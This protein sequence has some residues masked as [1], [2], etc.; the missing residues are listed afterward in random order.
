MRDLWNILS[1]TW[2][3]GFPHKI[4]ASDK[5]WCYQF[6]PSGKPESLQWKYPSLLKHKKCKMQTSSGKV[7][8]T[9]F[10]DVTCSLQLIFNRH[11]HTID[12]LHRQV[13]FARSGKFNNRVIL[14]HDNASPHV[15]KVVQDELKNMMR[16]VL[17]YPPYS[18]NL[19]PCPLHVYGPLKNV[20]TKWQV[21]LGSASE[22]RCHW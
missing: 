4:L 8:L 5:K 7:M 1:S 15:S 9:L 13:K 2:L 21:F 17:D 18:S 10:L 11:D 6:E 19:C 22:R 12:K 3:R 14:L 20:L 16:D